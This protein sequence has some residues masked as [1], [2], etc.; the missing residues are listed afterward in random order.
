MRVTRVVGLGMAGIVVIAAVIA[1]WSVRPQPVLGPRRSLTSEDIQ[2]IESTI[3][4]KVPGPETIDKIAL[5]H[6]KDCSLFIKICVPAECGA[7]MRG[8][9]SARARAVKHSDVLWSRVIP[10]F[11]L[12]EEKMDVAYEEALG[13]YTVFEKPFAGTT[14]IYICVGGI[15]K[16]IGPGVYRIFTGK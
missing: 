16:R 14:T 12:A 11:S 6:G 5:L 7:A 10:W 13:D 8:V 1:L 4:L 3:G 2:A 15:S 9:V